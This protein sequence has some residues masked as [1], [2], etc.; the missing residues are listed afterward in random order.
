MLQPRTLLLHRQNISKYGRKLFGETACFGNRFEL[1][2]DIF[3]IALLSRANAAYDDNDMLPINSVNDTMASELV[4]P[5]TCQRSTQ[6]Q[7]VSFRVNS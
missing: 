7:S 3:R 5:I 4:L 6:R 1:P 2:V